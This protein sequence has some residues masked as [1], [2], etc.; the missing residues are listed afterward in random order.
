[1]MTWLGQYQGGVLRSLAT[2]LRTGGATAAALAFSLG[3][4]HALTPGHGKGA[5]V[6]YFL[7][8]DARAGTG[9][10]IALSAALLHVLSGLILFLILRLAFGIL[11]SITGRSSPAFA[12]V[13]YGLIVLSGAIMIWQSQRS[14]HEAAHGSYALTAGIGLLPC[15]LTISVL[16]FAWTQ[17]SAIMVGVVLVSLAL[18]IS[19]TIGLVALMAIA[20]RRGFGLAISNSMPGLERWARTLQAVAGAIIVIIGLWTMSSV[21]R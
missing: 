17:S 19:L 2:E 16:G 18:G 3:A 15:P 20:A 9:L 10:R 8:R 21:A 14:D 7:G 5:L 6:A 1:M 4:L 12:L 11:P 13:G